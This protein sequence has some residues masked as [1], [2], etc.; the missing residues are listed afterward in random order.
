MLRV[1][2]LRE[3]VAEA[4]ASIEDIKSGKVVVTKEEI[5][6]FMREHDR[7][8]NTLL[9]G[10][11]PEHDV[12]GSS[13]NFKTENSLGFYLLDKTDYS[14]DDQDGFLDIFAKVQETAYEFV[15]FILE[16]NENGSSAICGLFQYLDDVSFPITPIKGLEGCNGYF[17]G[18]SFDTAF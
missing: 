5:S 4:V 12:S 6:R 15:S 10:I 18:I 1:N 17:V 13:D 14:A 9:I 3:F 11:V 2:R 16:Q 8:D 7:S